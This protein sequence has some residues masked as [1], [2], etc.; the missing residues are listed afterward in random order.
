MYSRLVED[1]TKK[2]ILEEVNLFKASHEEQDWKCPACN[3]ETGVYQLKIPPES[4]TEA[5]KD[6]K[7]LI[8]THLELHKA[9]LLQRLSSKGELAAYEKSK[10]DSLKRVRLWITGTINDRQLYTEDP[11]ERKPQA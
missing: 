3:P 7:L 2:N 8:K 9:E 5:L 11:L 6:T 1:T 4:E 10:A